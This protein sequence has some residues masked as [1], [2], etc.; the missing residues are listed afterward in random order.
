MTATR[1][2]ATGRQRSTGAASRPARREAA[3]GGA[4]TFEPIEQL[5]AHEYV[6]EQIRRQI[7]LHL[8][9]VGGALPSERDLSTMF[10]V[11]RATI[12]AAIRLLEADRM[13]ETRRGRHGGTFVIPHDEDAIAKDYLLVRLRRDRERIEQALEYRGNV[14]RFAAALAAKHRT[15]EELERIRQAHERTAAAETDAEFMAHDT[16]FH[17]AL[18]RAAH[19]EFVYEAVE[20][21]RLVL[22]DAIAALPESSPWRRRTVKEHGAVLKAIEARR[23]DA[24]ARAMARHANGTARSVAALLSAL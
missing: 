21:M 17:L 16:E 9:P 11:G 24:A 10:G 6:A 3:D 20:Q 15:A 22:N 14:D 23:V 12:Q 4:V 18:A 19:N 13:V 2:Q 8:I 5:R 7:G 1:K